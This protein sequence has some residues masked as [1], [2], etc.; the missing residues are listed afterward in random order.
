MGLA[1]PQA[2]EDSS[3]EEPEVPL[4]GLA[5][6]LDLQ[7]RRSPPAHQVTQEKVKHS[8]KDRELEIILDRAHGYAFN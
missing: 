1:V 2:V 4:L 7:I 6:D 5:Q 3:E 8:K